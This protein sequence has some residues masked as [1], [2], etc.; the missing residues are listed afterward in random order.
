VLAPFSITG[1]TVLVLLVLV[2]VLYQL[3]AAT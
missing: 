1:I 2:L 3:V